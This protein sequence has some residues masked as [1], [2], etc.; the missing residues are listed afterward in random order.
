M[1][2]LAFVKC[3]NGFKELLYLRTNKYGG[4]TKR[5]N[6]E[7]EHILRKNGKYEALEITYIDRMVDEVESMLY[8]V[9]K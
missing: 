9:K 7:L 6:Q 4:M 8:M 2:R 3:D 1:S 5:Q